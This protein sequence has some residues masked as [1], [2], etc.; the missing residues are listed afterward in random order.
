MASVSEGVYKWEQ[1]YRY[2][3]REA[4]LGLYGW[5]SQTLNVLLGLDWVSLDQASDND[6]D[7]LTEIREAL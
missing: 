2:R 3:R 7:L 4:L 6:Q 1:H 5:K